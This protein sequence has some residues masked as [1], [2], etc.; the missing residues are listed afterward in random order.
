M[1]HPARLVRLPHPWSPSPPPEAPSHS[2]RSI[3]SVMFLNIIYPLIFFAC[4][5]RCKFHEG[6]EF[7]LFNSPLSPPSLEQSLAIAGFQNKHTTEYLIRNADRHRNGSH[8]HASAPSS[9]HLKRQA[10]RPKA[11]HPT[12]EQTKARRENGPCLAYFTLCEGIRGPL[13]HPQAFQPQG[14]FSMAGTVEALGPQEVP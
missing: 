14:A 5:P 7:C 13:Q 2:P 3:F 4:P 9:R 11:I 10:P 1:H 6:E 8:T 12:V